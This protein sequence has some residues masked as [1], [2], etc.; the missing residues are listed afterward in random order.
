V[1]P[2]QRSYPLRPELIESTYML[3]KATHDPM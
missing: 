1:Q 2:G 3:Y